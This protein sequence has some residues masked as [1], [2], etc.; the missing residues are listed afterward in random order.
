MI[1]KTDRG[2]DL[3]EFTDAYGIKCSLQKSSSALEDRIWIGCNDPDPRHC[4]PGEGWK[5]VELPSGTV[6]NTRMHLSRKQ[7]KDLLPLLQKFV[8]TGEL[9]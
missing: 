7:V 4:V 9:G 1:S 2:F 3:Y 8:D 5:S 6:S